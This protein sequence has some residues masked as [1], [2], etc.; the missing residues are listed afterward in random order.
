MT[1]YY[2]TTEFAVEAESLKSAEELVARRAQ[3]FLGRSEIVCEHCKE[4][5][6]RE[7]GA[8]GAR[9]CLDASETTDEGMLLEG[10]PMLAEETGYVPVEG[11]RPI[12][13]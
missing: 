9:L 1:R 3:D 11:G 2:V 6:L 10:A 7:G 4:S 13:E 12:G 5:T 8:A